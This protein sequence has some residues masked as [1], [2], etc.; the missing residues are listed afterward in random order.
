MRIFLV[1][2]TVRQ[3]FGCSMHAEQLRMVMTVDEALRL[4]R[5]LLEQCDSKDEAVRVTV[6]GEWEEQ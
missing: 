4:A 5:R 3:S 6:S 2:K 1:G